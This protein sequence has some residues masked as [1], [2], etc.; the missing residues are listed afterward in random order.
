[1]YFNLYWYKQIQICVN[2]WKPPFETHNQ[3][4]HGSSP[5][6]TTTKIKPF[7]DE[8]LCCCY[9]I[10][11]NNSVIYEKDKQEEELIAFKNSA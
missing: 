6:G 10:Q 1:M 11:F 3:G 5:C 2:V 4:V 9:T 8:G 7:R